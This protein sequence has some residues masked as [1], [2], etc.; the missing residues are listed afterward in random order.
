[1]LNIAAFY[2]HFGLETGQQENNHEL[3]DHIS[4]ELE[5]M[6]FLSFKE[7]HAREEADTEL[8]TGY[9]LAQHDFLQRHLLLWVPDFASK[10][11]E[12]NPYSVLSAWVKLT[13][14]FLYVE[15]DLISACLKEMGVET[16]PYDEPDTIPV[17]SFSDDDLA[18]GCA[19]CQG[20]SPEFPS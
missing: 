4:A 7:A 3:P 13:A 14:N 17:T 12:I 18:S 6:H 9:V 19:A 2:K 1:M 20:A 15:M 16:T 11:E 8:L 10:I 5:F